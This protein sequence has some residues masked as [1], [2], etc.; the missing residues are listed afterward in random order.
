MEEKYPL[1][2]I[3]VPVYNVEK[4]LDRCLNSIVNQTYKNLEIILVDDGSPDNCPSMCDEWAE[5]D[6]RIK[7]IHKNNGGLSSARNAG[8]ELAV[9]DYIGFVDSDDWIE[10]DMYEYLYKLLQ[11]TD[12]DYSSIEMFIT[13]E[14]NYSLHQSKEITECLSTKQLLNIFFRVTS[15]EIK[16]CVCDKLFKSNIVKQIKFVNGIRFEDIMYNFEVLKKCKKAIYSNQIKYYWFVNNEGITNS[17]ICSVDMQMLDVWNQIVNECEK[18]FPDFTYYA[19]INRYRAALALLGKYVKYGVNENYSEWNA[20]KK[21]LEKELRKN[22]FRLMKWKLP[23]S[24]K[25][26]LTGLCISSDLCRMLYKIKV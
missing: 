3:I 8:I 20:D 16:Y 25:V 21:D 7:V 1:I 4:Y 11:Y 5:K 19:L 18:E 22:Y 15:N 6:A 17:S 2:S 9:G 13:K 14:Y 10:K 23:F 24:R 26:L 12:A